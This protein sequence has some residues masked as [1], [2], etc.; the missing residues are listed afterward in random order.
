MTAEI[1]TLRPTRPE[2]ES[3]VWVCRCGCT[4]HYH[5]S[6]DTVE[7]GTCGNIATDLTGEW[8]LKLPEAPAEPSELD[9]SNFKVTT[10]DS[11]AIFL[12]RHAK[13]V[14]ADVVAILILHDDGTFA[15]WSGDMTG[16]DRA[17]WLMRQLTKVWDR[18]TGVKP[19]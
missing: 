6:D 16:P 15:T 12:Q 18:L 14:A 11:P 4:T 3:L 17:A 8:R 7:C 13:T 10:L 5:R 19:I 2:P 9:S 1:V